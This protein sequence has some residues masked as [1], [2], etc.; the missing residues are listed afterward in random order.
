MDQYLIAP[1]EPAFVSEAE[2]GVAAAEEVKEER[3]S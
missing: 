1:F 3:N 2:A